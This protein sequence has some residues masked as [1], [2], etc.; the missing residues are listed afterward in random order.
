MIAERHGVEAELVERFGNLLALVVR[1]KESALELITSVEPER[2]LL[3]GSQ[4]VYGVLYAGIAAVAAAAGVGAV[5]TRGGELVEM[6]MNVVDVE[7]GCVQ[8]VS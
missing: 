8:V 2:R 7:E 3:L 5:G 4:G 6:G 1:V